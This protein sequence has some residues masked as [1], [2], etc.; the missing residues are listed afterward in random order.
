[1]KSI[2][3]DTHDTPIKTIKLKQLKYSVKKKLR[4]HFHKMNSKDAI[5]RE[6]YNGWIKFN[7]LMELRTKSGNL[8]KYPTSVTLKKNIVALW[9]VMMEKIHTDHNRE[10]IDFIQ[11]VCLKRWKGDTA[12]GLGDFVLKC[13]L[14][15]IMEDDDWINFKEVYKS[16][17]GRVHNPK[18][19]INTPHGEGCIKGVINSNIPVLKKKIIL[20]KATK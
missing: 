17:N 19:I 1:M 13:M 11:N 8:Y 4:T 10:I 6:M 7:I 5:V 3:L 14:H 9:L 15:A 16:L 20:K 2:T 12:K 18:K